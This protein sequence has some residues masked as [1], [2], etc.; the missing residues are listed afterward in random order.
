MFIAAHALSDRKHKLPEK[1]KDELTA[2]LCEHFNKKEIEQKDIDIASTTTLHFHTYH[3]RT[4]FQ[5]YHCTVRLMPLKP[6]VPLGWSCFLE[7]QF[8]FLDDV[9]LQKRLM[10]SWLFK[11]CAPPL[12]IFETFASQSV[13]L[14][15]CSI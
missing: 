13:C 7:N 9:V 8:P 3:K 14:C 6:E 10:V 5:T 12:M 4:K 11:S 1:R 15:V 2:L